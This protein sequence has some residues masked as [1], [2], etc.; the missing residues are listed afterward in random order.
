MEMIDDKSLFPEFNIQG[1]VN[2]LLT[3][4]KLGIPVLEPTGKEGDFDKDLVD[5]PFIFWHN[6]KFYMTYVGFDGNGYRSGLASSNNL[7]NWKREKLI[8]DWGEN[9]KFDCF[10]AGPISIL[11]ENI[12]L[13][14]LPIP[15]KWFGKY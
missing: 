15:K 12:D 6:N 5:C 8:L 1:L 7:I 9:G 4:F 14:K 11:L 13:G 10:G 3:P 2:E